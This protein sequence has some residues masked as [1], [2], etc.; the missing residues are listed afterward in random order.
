MPE[1]QVNPFNH[2]N[3]CLHR[4][5]RGIVFDSFVRPSFHYAVFSVD[6]CSTVYSSVNTNVSSGTPCS[7]NFFGLDFGAIHID[8]TLVSLS[9]K[10]QAYPWAGHR[11]NPFG[12]IIVSFAAVYFCG[13]WSLWSS[14]G[15]MLELVEWLLE[16]ASAQAHHL[17]HRRSQT[18]L[19]EGSLDEQFQEGP[20]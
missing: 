14:F 2:T 11:S 3:L 18:F 6:F 15:K 5:A 8:F 12:Q 13:C 10:A 16:N 9:H 19:H 4:R 17:C 20:G 7:I 1:P